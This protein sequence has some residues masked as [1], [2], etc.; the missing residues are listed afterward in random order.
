[1]FV[2][3]VERT[4]V[5]QFL[6]INICTETNYFP[7]TKNNKM[8]QCLIPDRTEVKHLYVDCHA[9]L[10]L[11]PI[12]GLSQSQDFVLQCVCA[13]I[14]KRTATEISDKAASDCASEMGGCSEC[15]LITKSH[16]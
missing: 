3:E 9:V 15:G 11:D 14:G 16:S 4:L 8:Y 12:S 1:M 7:F 5:I 2:S 6:R 13:V 10:I